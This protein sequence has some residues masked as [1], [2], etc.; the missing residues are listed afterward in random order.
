MKRVIRR[1]L[2][3]SNSSSI[4]SLV[5]MSDNENTDWM[6][7]R[8]WL[9]NS[10]N[11]YRKLPNPPE[12]GKLYNRDEVRSFISQ[13]GEMETENNFSSE[14]EFFSAYA[15][16]SYDVWSSNEYLEYEYE[17]YVTSGGEKIIVCCKYGYE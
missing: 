8:K 5:I 6:C 12:I 7:G 3:E 1:N 14:D 10:R 15:F 16:E 13:I 17:E 4:H 11:L 2:F 9:C